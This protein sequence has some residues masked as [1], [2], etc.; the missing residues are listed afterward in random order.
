[1]CVY[2]TNLRTCVYLYLCLCRICKYYFMLSPVLL[3]GDNCRH[4]LAL[5]WLQE[6]HPCLQSVSQHF[7]RCL[8]LFIFVSLY[9]CIFVIVYLW[10][11]TS[12]ILGPSRRTLA[13][14][15]VSVF[16][17]CKR[18]LGLLWS[19]M[20]FHLGKPTYTKTCVFS[21]FFQSCCGCF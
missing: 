14:I 3:L 20:A 8:Y 10:T 21:M 19:Y 9:L 18:F 11:Y 12:H 7:W 16:T 6:L 17:I 4:H 15:A 13:F 1:M 5:T 2:A